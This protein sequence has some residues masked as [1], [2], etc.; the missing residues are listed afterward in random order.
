MISAMLITR[1]MTADCQTI[2]HAKVRLSTMRKSDYQRR[3][4]QTIDHA[5][6]RLSTVMK[7]DYHRWQS[8]E[9]HCEKVKLS[10][11]R[12]SDYRLWQNWTI[13]RCRSTVKALG[14]LEWQ[15]VNKN[16][17]ASRA[18]KTMVVNKKASS[19][20]K[21]IWVMRV[22]RVIRFFGCLGLGGFHRY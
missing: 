18:S 11:V 1:H 7:L 4:G 3:E 17:K 19:A 10:P 20:I 9:I 14:H 22:I 5:K 21:T 13:N 2:N 12:N 16:K 8:R 6:V 15:E